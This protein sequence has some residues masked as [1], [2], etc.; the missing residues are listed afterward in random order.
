V[1][2]V[3]VLLLVGAG[4][5][6]AW[7]LVSSSGQTSRDR[8]SGTPPTGAGTTPVGATRAGGRGSNAVTIN[9]TVWYAGLKLTFG[10]AS[11]QGGDQP[12]VTVELSIENLGTAQAGG[13][14][15]ST[16]LGTGGKFYDGRLDG[17]TN[18]PG[19]VTSKARLL[20]DVGGPVDLSSAVITVGGADKAQAVVPL[21][22][23]GKLVSLEPKTVLK[24]AK[25]NVR[26]LAM[27]VS[28]C[29]LRS[30]LVSDHREV[31][32]NSASV[33]CTVDLKYTGNSGGGHLV[34]DTNFRLKLPDGTVVAPEKYPIEDLNTD[35]VKQG[36]TLRFT[37]RWPAPGGYAL[38]LLDL[39][40]TGNETPSAANTA[41]VDVTI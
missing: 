16:T 1:A 35:G 20:F 8:G 18:V 30:D 40:T 2:A 21:D 33:A 14:E 27:S 29:E 3:V 12:R 36:E 37:I 9:R 15:A 4:A 34:V 7:T 32:R 41:A 5:V 31:D 13:Y 23:N 26:T 25:I 24:D 10:T 6:K 39:G 28:V 19:L 22:P 17:I 11:Y 38:Q